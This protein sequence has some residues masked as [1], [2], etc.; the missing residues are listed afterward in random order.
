MRGR[1]GSRARRRSREHDGELG[2]EQQWRAREREAEEEEGVCEKEEPEALPCGLYGRRGRGVGSGCGRVARCG[3]AHRK[4]NRQTG[5]KDLS[6][7]S[8]ACDVGVEAC[9]YVKSRV[10]RGPQSIDCSREVTTGRQS[11]HIRS[12]SARDRI[13]EK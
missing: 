2:A 4:S 7:G 1:S 12:E 8:E 10:G 3:L 11:V 9:S 13:F 5:A 6:V